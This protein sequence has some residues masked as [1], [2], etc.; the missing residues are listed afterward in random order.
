[1]VKAICKYCGQ[2]KELINSHIIP[3]SLCQTDKFG[4]MVG[5]NS[6]SKCFDHNPKHQNKYEKSRLFRRLVQNGERGGT[7]TLG[8]LIKSQMLYRL[9][10][11]LE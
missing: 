10:Y 9:S 11:A 7:R 1:M 8:P 5:V 4:T 3:K 2:E 6:V